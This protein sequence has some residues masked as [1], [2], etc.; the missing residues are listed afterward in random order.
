MP[1][2][3][4]RSV[5]FVRINISQMREDIVISKSDGREEIICE[6]SKSWQGAL[7]Y[8]WFTLVRKK[9]LNS[10]AF[11]SLSITNLSLT[12]SGGTLGAFDLY[13]FT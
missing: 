2:Y 10:L 7:I 3:Y 1:S 9:S 13:K 8:I 5:G 4:I 12:F 11:S 6:W